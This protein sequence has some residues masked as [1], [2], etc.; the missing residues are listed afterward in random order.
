MIFIYEKILL[1]KRDNAENVLQELRKA[2]QSRI[3]SQLSQLAI[4]NLKN[5]VQAIEVL[6]SYGLRYI[7]DY[8]KTFPKKESREKANLLL[9]FWSDINGG[10]EFKNLEDRFDTHASY[11]MN[12]LCLVIGDHAYRITEC[13]IYYHEGDKHPDPFVHR[14]S[15]Q[16]YAGNWYF[17]DMGI[18]LT[19]GNYDKK[20]YAS[21][22]IRGIRNLKTNRYITGPS[23][24]VREIFDK[25]GNITSEPPVEQPE[26]EEEDV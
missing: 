22:L 15:Q 14:R 13:E 5:P 20:I 26:E 1:E 2:N 19:F 16:L 8:A 10:F 21:I 11:L 6:K 24:V 3:L 18:D 12:H 7:D 25:F 4:D 23:N 9:E 17:N